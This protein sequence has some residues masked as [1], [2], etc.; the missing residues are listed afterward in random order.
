MA[1]RSKVNHIDKI[2]GMF[3]VLESTNKR[4][5]SGN[6]IWIVECMQCGNKKEISSSNLRN[7]KKC[8]CRFHGHSSRNK[9][10]STYHSWQAM[11]MRC[12]NSNHNDYHRYGG[13]G[14]KVCERW[15]DS[16]ENFLEDMG[17]RPEGMTLDRIDNDGHYEPNNCKWSMP[18]EQSQNSSMSKLN[19]E[20]VKRIKWLLELN[21][22][23]LKQIAEMFNVSDVVISNIKHNKTWKNV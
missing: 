13:R 5:K 22:H 11:K 14:I 19:I 17:E 12:L 7:A 20:Q 4:N 8:E 10:T 23:S 18:Y 2:Y 16:F 15:L 1:G 21:R 3:R 6:V 9:I